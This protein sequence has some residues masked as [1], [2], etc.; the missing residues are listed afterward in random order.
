M[1][2]T[3]WIGWVIVN[4]LFCDT[5]S[6]H[7]ELKISTNPTFFTFLFI[8]LLSKEMTLYFFDINVVFAQP[9][10]RTTFIQRHA[11][12]P[13]RLSTCCSFRSNSLYYKLSPGFLECR[14]FNH[15]EC[16]IKIYHLRWGYLC[17]IS[18][19]LIILIL[20]I[21][22]QNFKRTLH[23]K[24]LSKETLDKLYLS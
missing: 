4:L 18:P 8:T 3:S 15:S 5:N 14:Y 12:P 22:N 20:T 2:R 19:S 17:F 10:C 7:I 13:D 1:W 16:I 23:Y 9:H 6:K 11:I 21:L 24:T